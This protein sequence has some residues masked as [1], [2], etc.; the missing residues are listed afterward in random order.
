MGRKTCLS[1][2][3]LI[4]LAISLSAPTFAQT[5]DHSSMPDMPG[6]DHAVN[7]MYGHHMEMRPHMKMTALRPAQPGDQQRADAVAAESRKVLAQ[8]TDYKVALQDGF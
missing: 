4:L 8:Y 2:F 3:V 6:M 7:A 5:T 1:V